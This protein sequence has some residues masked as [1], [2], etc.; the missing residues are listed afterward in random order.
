MTTPGTLLCNRAWAPL[1]CNHHPLDYLHYRCARTATILHL[2]CSHLMCPSNILSIKGRAFFAATSD[3]GTRTLSL[4]MGGS[5]GIAPLLLVTVPLL[6]VACALLA[7][8][9][10]GMGGCYAS[11]PPCLS[12]SLTL[13]PRRPP[14]SPDAPSLAPRKASLGC[15]T[16]IVLKCH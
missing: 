11:N 16:W 2:I 13:S 9:H 1:R 3:D 5:L 8:S 6:S 10:S 4:S 12:D 15:R 7:L 14:V